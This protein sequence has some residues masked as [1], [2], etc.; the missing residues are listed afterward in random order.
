[1]RLNT[2]PV[3]TKLPAKLVGMERA[4]EFVQRALQGVSIEVTLSNEMI[5]FLSQLF[6]H[7]QIIVRSGTTANRPTLNLE[8]GMMYFDTTLGMPI[9]VDAAGTGWVDATGA[10]A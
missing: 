2:P 1:M 8:T 7:A 6:R 10:A 4:P 5:E 3:Q 9:W